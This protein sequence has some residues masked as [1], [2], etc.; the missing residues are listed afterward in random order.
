MPFSSTPASSSLSVLENGDTIWRT[1]HGFDFLKRS[2]FFPCLYCFKI[3]ENSLRTGQN[4][5]WQV[6]RVDFS[7]L[8]EPVKWHKSF[9]WWLKH[10]WQDSQLCDNDPLCLWLI[11][12]TSWILLLVRGV[13]GEW[14]HE[15]QCP[16]WPDSAD[17]ELPKHPNYVFEFHCP[18][19][20]WNFLHETLAGM[21]VYSC[22]RTILSVYCSYNKFGPNREVTSQ[23]SATI[24][25]NLRQQPHCL[26]SAKCS[27]H[28][29]VTKQMNI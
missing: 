22:F 15:A 9:Y 3:R 10:S 28:Q 6:Q 13:S 2:A 14:L 4:V 26:I 29:H 20:E 8:Q 17:V 24:N 27:A 23:K 18:C 19:M 21:T 16:F 5:R 25:F 7:D 12:I 1:P 11:K